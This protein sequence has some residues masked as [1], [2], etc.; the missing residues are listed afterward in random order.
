[1]DPLRVLLICPDPGIPLHGPS[2][3]S[4]HLRGIAQ[5]LVRRGLKVR[6][7]VPRDHDH[8]GRHDP[9]LQGVEVV[10]RPPRTWPRGVQTLGAWADTRALLEAALADGWRP[11]WIWERHTDRGAAGQRAAARL[12]VPRLIELNAPIARER[13]WLAAR[14]PS[15]RIEARERR[16]LR[17][18]TRVIAVSAWLARWAS[19]QMGCDPARVRWVPNGIA[20]GPAGDGQAVRRALGLSGRVVGFLGS[21]KPWHGLD[22]LPAILDRLGTGWT[23]LI[24]GTGPAPIPVHPRI[25]PLGR[26][27]DA[28]VADHVAALDVGLVPSSINAPPWF[29]PLKILQYRAQGVPV[30]AS[31]T[32]SHRQLI[33]DGGEVLA[34]DDPDAWAQAIVRQGR[35]RPPP[36]IRTWDQVLDEALKDLC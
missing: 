18:A 34:S 7:A 5:A 30:V 19:T 31:D 24:L 36:K 9:D 13:A 1:M 10:L 15:R 4:V 35:R 33:G 23:A 16:S 11:D 26:L 2:G 29:C 22:R 12:G 28:A 8:R 14:P 21:V 25:Q 20:P 17:A 32:E 6:L 3:A 27:D